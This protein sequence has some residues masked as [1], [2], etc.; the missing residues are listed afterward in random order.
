MIAPIMETSVA[1]K[2]SC[3]SVGYQGNPADSG[4]KEILLVLAVIKELVM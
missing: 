1:I 4:G 3:Q 2:E